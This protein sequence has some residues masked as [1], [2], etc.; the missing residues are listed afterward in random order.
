[1]RCC[2]RYAGYLMLYAMMRAPRGRGALVDACLMRGTCAYAQRIHTRI[3]AMLPA[4]D[5]FDALIFMLLMAITMMS[6]SM[7]PMIFL[8]LIFPE[9]DI[10]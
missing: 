6:F 9:A 2:L 4:F 5:M 8:M 1:M 3:Y 10:F 7:P